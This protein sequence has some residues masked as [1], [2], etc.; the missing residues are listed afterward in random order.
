MWIT[1]LRS[2]GGLAVKSKCP[3]AG[4]CT[5]GPP[6]TLDGPHPAVPL[7]FSELGELPVSRSFPQSFNKAV[8]SVMDGHLVAKW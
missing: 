5:G 3:H 1:G 8:K 7:L 6:E 4:P 2:G